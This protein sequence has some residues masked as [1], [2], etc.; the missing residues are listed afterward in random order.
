MVLYRE[1]GVELIQARGE[2]GRFTYQGDSMRLGAFA[3]RESWYIGVQRSS[4]GLVARLSLEDARTLKE[5]KDMLKYGFFLRTDQDPDLI[6]RLERIGL[7]SAPALAE[8]NN[9]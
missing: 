3:A 7:L 5:A 1:S 6:A 9:N 8:S 4:G 2:E